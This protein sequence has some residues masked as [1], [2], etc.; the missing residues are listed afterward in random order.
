M[1]K[2]LAVLLI[3][4]LLIPSMAFAEKV[5]VRWFVGLGTGSREEQIEPQEKVV[6]DFNKSQDEI[7]LVLEIVPNA[8]AFDVLA[9]QITAGNVPDIVGP[10]GIRS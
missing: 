8:Q 5:K 6:A 3:G 1:K 7:E 9:T 4:F 10:I 2:L